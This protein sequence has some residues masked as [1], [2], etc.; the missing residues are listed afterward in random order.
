MKPTNEKPQIQPL[1]EIFNQIILTT[2]FNQKQKLSKKLSKFLAYP[3]KLI[4][5]G[6]K[7]SQNYI[8][9][10]IQT[11]QIAVLKTGETINKRK[12]KMII[13]NRIMWVKIPQ[14]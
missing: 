2:Q 4:Q 5:K 10:K 11:I 8:E 3:I 1:H 13:Q 14:L 7:L 6:K 9:R 12:N